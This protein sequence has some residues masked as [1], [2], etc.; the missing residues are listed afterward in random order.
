MSKLC[1]GCKA[2]LP[3]N[4]K[5][6]GVCGKRLLQ[7]ADKTEI[8]APEQPKPVVQQ[9]VVQPVVQQVQPVVQPVIQ[10][11]QPVV[12]P[13]AATAAEKQ[14]ISPEKTKH[15]KAIL[16]VILAAAVCAAAVTALIFALNSNPSKKLEN[17]LDNAAKFMF[18]QDYG[19]AIS[20]F[21]KALEIDPTNAEAYLGKARSCHAAGDAEKAIETLKDGYCETADERIWEL[22][23]EY[24]S[25]ILAF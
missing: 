4:A 3:D 1:P 18:S 13:A 11:V 12:Q 6:C 5:F 17:C 14:K 16:G 9:P 7:P 2:V 8:L 19:Q 25:S 15:S 21:D 23:T 24:D 10:Q 20:E 22:L